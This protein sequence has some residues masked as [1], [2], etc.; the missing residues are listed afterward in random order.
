M[1]AKELA[2]H[3]CRKMVIDPLSALEK[4][5]DGLVVERVARSVIRRHSTGRSAPP[6]FSRPIS[7]ATSSGIEEQPV[8]QLQREQLMNL[9]GVVPVAF[10]VALH[11]RF[12]PVVFEVRPRERPR[13]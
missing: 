10:E 3:A 5:T 2:H 1:L 9:G 7:V 8:Q 4:H 13:V 11:H 12:E 6:P